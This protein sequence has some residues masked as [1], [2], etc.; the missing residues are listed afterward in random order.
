M[1]CV[2]PL[3]TEVETYFRHAVEVARN[4]QAKSPE[5]RAV[6]SLSRLWQHQGKRAE[7][8]Q[9]LAGTYEWFTEGFDTLDLQE[10]KALLEE[11]ACRWSIAYS[12]E[13]I[14]ATISAT[15]QSTDRHDGIVGQEHW[16]FQRDS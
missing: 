2:S 9:I 14:S 11:L 7:A 4:Q 8:Y 10:A 5:L 16:H 3:Q 12:E 15:L 1:T 13:L 6:V